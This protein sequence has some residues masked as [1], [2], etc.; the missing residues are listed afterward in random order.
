MF[1]YIVPCLLITGMKIM[2]NQT[3]FFLHNSVKLKVKMNNQINKKAFLSINT[4]AREKGRQ[5]QS[6]FLRFT[7]YYQ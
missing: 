4:Y 3:T 6:V 7:Q 1:C 2:S 5:R